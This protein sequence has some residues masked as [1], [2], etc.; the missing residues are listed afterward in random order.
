MEETA[1]AKINLA[2]HVR[3]R[4]ADGYHDI[5]TLFAFAAT[6]DRLLV[7]PSEAL[8]LAVTGP[9]AVQLEGVED[10]LVLRAADALRNRYGVGGG[11]TLTLEKY[12]PVASG[13]GGGSA[14]AAAALRLLNRWWEIGADEGELLE[15][16][17]TLGA[18]VPACVRSELV[19]GVGRGDLLSSQDPEGIAGMPLLLV[20]PRILVST[21]EVFAA[22]DGSDRGPLGIASPLATALEGR[23]DLE[24][25]ASAIAPEIRQVLAILSALPGAIL[26]RMSGSGATCFA[27][28][29]REEDCD[30]AKDVVGALQPNWWQLATQL[31]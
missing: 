16:A 22:W 9:F 24:A 5:E 27:L 10:N 15:I 26:S 1:Y 7:A 31:R 21:A 8:T 30:A 20:N 4:E 12:L 3:V 18:D 6:G 2:L 17:G 11:A 19:R 23:N 13:I 25:P 28:F 29:A 14:D